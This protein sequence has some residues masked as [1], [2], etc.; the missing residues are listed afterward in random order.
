M[1]SA[2]YYSIWNACIAQ[3]IE[4]FSVDIYH[5]NDY[6]GALAPLH[7]LPR[8]VPCAVSLH[9]AEYQGLWPL[10]TA[11]EQ[12]EVCAAFNIDVT[13]MKRYVQFG[14]VFNLLHAAASYIRIHQ[15]GVGVVGVSD[16]YSER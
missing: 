13:T 1:D 4:R 3:A 9:N 11:G 2:M 12:A 15:Q 16:K 5:I 6:H 7:L 10:R 14:T 8:A